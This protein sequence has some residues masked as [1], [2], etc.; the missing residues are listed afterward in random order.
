VRHGRYKGPSTS[1]DYKKNIN[2]DLYERGGG[3]KGERAREGGM[4]VMLS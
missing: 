3:G 4:E 2:R 1:T